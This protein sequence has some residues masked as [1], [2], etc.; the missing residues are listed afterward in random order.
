M[1]KIRRI[2]LVAAFLLAACSP[3]KNYRDLPEQEGCSERWAFQR[4]QA[5][6][7]CRRI[8]S[9]DWVDQRWTE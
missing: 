1:N 9:M 5:S 8:Q 4:R 6:P 7:E 3:L 2:S